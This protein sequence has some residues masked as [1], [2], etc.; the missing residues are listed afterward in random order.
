MMR[1]I[2][3][4]QALESL[5]FKVVKR[6]GGY[7]AQCPA[8]H[9][10]DL[11]L[12]INPGKDGRALLTCHSHGCTYESILAALQLTGTS[13]RPAA[14]S[15]SGTR[16]ERRPT[17]ATTYDYQ[18]ADGA[19]V[20]QT[21]R[22]HPKRFF[23]RRPDGHG[24]WINDLNGV[25]PVPFRL[26]QVLAADKDVP[27]LVAEGEKDVLALESL[28]FVATCNHGG[29]GRWQDAHSF[30]L[31][32]RHV[33]VI[34]DN[35]EPGRH[36]ANTVAN[37]LNGIAASVKVM[38][39]LPSVPEKGD[40]SDWIAGGGTAADLQ[41]LID[42]TP[43]VGSPGGLPGGPQRQPYPVDCLPPALRRLADEA[44]ETLGIPV[45]FIATVGLSVLA[46]A[47]PHNLRLAAKRSWEEPAIL[48]TAIIGDP[49]TAKSPAIALATR[50]VGDLQKEAYERH[51]AERADWEHTPKKE[52]GPEPKLRIFMTTDT[53]FEGLEKSLQDSGSVLCVLDEL[54]SWFAGHS[55]YRGSGASERSQWLSLWPG[56]RIVVNRATKD[57]LFIDDPSVS[58]TGGIQPDLLAEMSKAG[59]QTSQNDGMLDRFLFAWPDA[60]PADLTDEEIGEETLANWSNLVKKL[61]RASLDRPTIVRLTPEAKRAFK[62]WYREN[63]RSRRETRGLALGFAAKASGHLLRL[64][65][66]LHAASRP[67]ALDTDVPV[68]TLEAAITLLEYYR[69]HHGLV[70]MALEA[71]T[72][73]PPA[74][75]TSRVERLIRTAPAEPDDGWIDRTALHRGLGNSVK[76]DELDAVLT[77]LLASN[78]I[79]ETTISSG[80]RPRQLYAHTSRTYEHM[81]IPALDLESAAAANGHRG[82]PFSDGDLV[83]MTPT[84]L[85]LTPVCE[86]CGLEH[87]RPQPCPLRTDGE[88]PLISRE[89]ERVEPEPNHPEMED[90]L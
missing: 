24:G 48:F 69:E 81:K 77:D 42:A 65:L 11:N 53:T 57:A 30:F 15:E 18:D 80:G 8:H 16:Q 44:W 31:A 67:H 2:E 5:G 60:E 39:S 37:S 59:G 85:D 49:G 25:A 62:E 90:Q 74:G 14:P 45:D 40:P 32:G 33:V 50:P 52:R 34:A 61:F 23:Q 26:P 72:A 17:I 7:R 78:R 66:V 82:P 19:V 88:S 12:A 13:T 3:I 46:T 20:F 4:V 89:Q 86:T 21:V 35:D 68:E 27:I 70:L 10:R 73:S 79:V 51:K 22:M 83:S 9:G 1:V 84:S 54:T 64:T 87:P 36:H 38:L 29:A 55:R 41:A 58:V 63:N 6:G 28:G 75:L 47:V 43:L 71:G 56:G 76:A